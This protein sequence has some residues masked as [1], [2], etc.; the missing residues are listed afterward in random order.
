MLKF[1]I[2]M[3]GILLLIWLLAVATPHI[4]RFVDKLF[5]KDKPDG[6]KPERVQDNKNDAAEYTVH[7][8]YEGSP[9]ENENNT[10]NNDKKD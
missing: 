9:R 1:G 4:A 2:G 3:V 8:I 10:E 6:S 7:D 5:G